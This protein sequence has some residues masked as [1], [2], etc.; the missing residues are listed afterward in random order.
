MT[1]QLPAA[2]GLFGALIVTS[3]I[4]LA[5]PTTGPAG[6]WEGAIEVPG[7]ALEIEIDLA[8]AGETWEGT[9]TIP[10]QGLK[11]VPLSD[12]TVEGNAVS[13]AMKG[14]PGDPQ[15]KGTVS[16]DAKSLSGE[17]SQG[18]ATLP[19]ALT[20]TGDAKIEPPPESTPI[21]A[22][23]EGSWEGAV[24]DGK[25]KTL[26]LV[27]KLSNQP[28]GVAAGTLVSLDQ[29]GGA[30]IPILAVVQAGSHLTLD[31]RAVTGTYEGDFDAGQLT[32]TWTQAGTTQPL[33][34]KRQK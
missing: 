5:Q 28:D 30:E 34:F 16:E 25:G 11:G 1:K 20:R 14:P 17:Y 2:L 21:T 23:L 12:I 10:V 13:F 7:Q 26:R 18:D 19:F 8:E 29:G 22:D 27:L 4:T 6:H 31:V 24:V 15:F 32:G 33:V 9:I 3:S